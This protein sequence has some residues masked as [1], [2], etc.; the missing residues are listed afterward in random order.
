MGS[1][2]RHLTPS[3]QSALLIWRVWA[4]VGGQ[5]PWRYHTEQK[6]MRKRQRRQWQQLNF[7]DKAHLLTVYRRIGGLEATTTL[8]RHFNLESANFYGKTWQRVH[9]YIFR[10]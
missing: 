7:A 10:Y 8:T 9:Y 4:A 1:G 5:R 3:L 2:R 6:H